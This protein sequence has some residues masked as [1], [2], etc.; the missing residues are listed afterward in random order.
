MLLF[1]CVQLEIFVHNDERVKKCVKSV[2]TVLK[3]CVL[4][5]WIRKVKF[6]IH[7][8]SK[9]TRIYN[10]IGTLKG[11][12]EPGNRSICLAYIGQ[13]NLI[14]DYYSGCRMN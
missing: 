5:L 11:A 4:C 12:I 3:Q 10:V 6:H 13:S 9:V 1:A 8:Y 2:T 14:Y 7:S